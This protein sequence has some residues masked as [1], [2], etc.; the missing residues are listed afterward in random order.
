MRVRVLPDDDETC[1]WNAMLPAPEPACRLTGRLDADWLVL[2]AGFTGLAAAR[3]LAEH[4]PDARVVLVEA[5][6]LGLG[7]SGRNSGFAVDVGHPHGSP[8]NERRHIRLARAGIAALRE[9]VQKHGI[10]CDW[11]GRGRLHGA[12][13]RRSVRALEGLARRLDALGEPFAWLDAAAVAAHTGT[14]YYA[15]AVHTPGTVLLQPAALARGLARTLPANVELFEESP[16][17]ELQLGRENRVACRSGLASARGIVLA[18]NGLLPALG[19][20]RSRVLP[21]LTF[22]SLTRPLRDDEEAALGGEP[23]WGLVPEDTLGTTVR[24]GCRGR[25]LIRNTVHCTP[26]LRISDRRR[27]RIARRH[28]DALRARFPGLGGVQIE[29]TWGGLIGVSLND[30]PCFGDV[31][32][33]VFAAGAYSGVGISMGTAAGMLIADLAVGRESPLLDDR[34]ALPR[35]AWLPPD[36]LRTVGARAALAFLQARAGAER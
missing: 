1:G 30:S 15:A 17:L 23:V 21:L 2:G 18:T 26:P 8:E 9:T 7:A 27:P 29:H 12:V 10:E 20:L 31:A 16:V 24:R 32:R 13:G 25:I 35:P 6:R 22:A 3:R 28:R 14:H 19:F 33:G 5:Q 11:T 34:L 4:D 36:P